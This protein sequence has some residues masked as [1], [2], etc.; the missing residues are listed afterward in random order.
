M[1]PLV[2]S[3]AHVY[4][5]YRTLLVRHEMCYIG[6]KLRGND[7]I[8]LYAPGLRVYISKHTY[9]SKANENTNRRAK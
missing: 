5:I 7:V 6:V 1:R 9:V 8:Q 3:H 4:S 2:Y